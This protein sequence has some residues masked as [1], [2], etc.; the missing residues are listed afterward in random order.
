MYIKKYL[1]RIYYCLYNKIKRCQ[2][3]KWLKLHSSYYDNEMHILWGYRMLIEERPFVRTS[4]WNVR[5]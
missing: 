5:Y 1:S 3:I 2:L 4:L